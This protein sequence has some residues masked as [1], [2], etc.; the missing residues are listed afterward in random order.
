MTG[1]LSV[2][3]AAAQ[4]LAGKIKMIFAE[5]PVPYWTEYMHDTAE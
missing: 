5:G 1:F 2:F 3:P 4:F